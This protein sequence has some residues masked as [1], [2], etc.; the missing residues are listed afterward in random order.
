VIGGRTTRNGLRTGWP[1]YPIEARSP[2]Y[3][4]YVRMKWRLLPS[5]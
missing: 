4:S 5:A 1:L 2:I 3:R